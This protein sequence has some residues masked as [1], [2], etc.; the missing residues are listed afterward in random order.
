[1]KRIA[2]FADTNQTAAIG[3]GGVLLFSS[4]DS[5]GYA[6][7]GKVLRVVNSGTNTMAAE[8]CLGGTK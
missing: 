4:P 3:N 7:T 8:V 2:L 1:M 5:T 6:A